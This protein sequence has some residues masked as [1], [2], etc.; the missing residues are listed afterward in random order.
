MA[1]TVNKVIL[2]GHTGDD[3]KMKHFEGGGC[4][5]RFPLATNEEYVNRT[6][7]ERVSNTEWHNCVVRNKAAE[8]CEKYLRKGDKVYIEGRIKNRQWTGEDGQQRYTTEI[9]VQE[10]TFLTPKNENSN[11]GPQQQATQQQSNT[12]R[13]QAPVVPPEGS[14]EEVDDLPF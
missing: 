6:T 2:I 11:T 8:V 5:G 7:G 12:Q 10:F 13:Y 14:D 3:V 1:G 4:I 9:Q